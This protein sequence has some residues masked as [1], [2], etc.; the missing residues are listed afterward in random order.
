MKKNTLLLVLFAFT[1]FGYA[2]YL[3]EGFETSVPPSGWT[4]NSTNSGLYTWSLSTTNPHSGT[5]SAQVQYDPDLSSQNESL[6]SPIIDLTSATDPQLT[7]WFNMSYY[8]SVEVPNYDFIVSITDG[9]TTTPLW[10]HTDFGV[11]TNFVW[12]EVTLDLSTYAGSNNMQLVFS[13]V[14]VDGASLDIDDVLVAERPA[15]PEC[16]TA[17][18]TPLDGA[19]VPA[20]DL[21]TL[22]WTAPASGPTPTSYDVY[23]GEMSDGSDQAFFDNVATTSLEV[24]IGTENL[25]LY[26]SVI[27]LNETTEASGCDDL[28][29]F[30]SDSGPAVPVNDN[31]CN[32]T[33]LAMNTESAG[34]A[35]YDV[36]A[37]GQASEVVGS[38]F[39]AGVNGSVWFSFVAPASGEVTVSTDIAGG[40]HSDTEIAVYAA[41]SDCSN[42]ATLGAEQ[43]CTQDDNDDN[44]LST[45]EL[46]GLTAGATYYIQVDRWGTADPGYFGISV[47]DSTLSIDDETQNQFSYFPNPVKNTLHLN[48]QSNIQNVSIF[49]MLGQEVLKTAPNNVDSTVDM[50]NLQTGAYFVKVTI[51]DRT[52]TVR[53]VKQ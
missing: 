20:Y 35:Y 53:V 36:F 42:A 25:T 27:P 22:S 51:N 15:T 47:F 8:W 10:D 18:I 17:P 14:G 31:L 29:S 24:F 32:A 1:T 45:V 7:F 34:N 19:T 39:N 11:F 50:S 12:Y 46:T 41:P 21:F 3:S 37:T 2:Q 52:E 30:T 49:N 26:W 13:Y 43:G 4:L 23:V 5:Y 9:T 48:A 6:V 40:T 28:W 38:C 44:F 16:A 33:P